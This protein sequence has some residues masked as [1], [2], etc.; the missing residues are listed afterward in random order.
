[1]HLY[2]ILLMLFDD[3]QAC[4][5]EFILRE[6]PGV[7]LTPDPRPNRTKNETV[8]TRLRNQFAHKRGADL[9]QT[10]AEMKNCL[11]GLVALT[12]RTIELGP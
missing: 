4:V 9:D 8:Y 12:K 11:S 5:D 1:M 10:K 3:S 2:N 7:L 6:N